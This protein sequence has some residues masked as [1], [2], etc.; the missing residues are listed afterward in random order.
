MAVFWQFI[1]LSILISLFDITN[2]SKNWVKENIGQ[3][4][5]WFYNKKS[6]KAYV[7]TEQGVIA[8][9]DIE[10]EGN[11][12]WRQVLDKDDKINQFEL[13][14][15]KKSLISLSNSDVLRKW[16][17]LDGSLVWESK[18]FTKSNNNNNN[19]N[20]NNAD[21][22]IIGSKIV[23]IDNND[24]LS[25]YDEEEGTLIWK[26][27]IIAN[28]DKNS[29][30]TRQYKL[31]TDQIAKTVYITIFYDDSVI[32]KSYSLTTVKIN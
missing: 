16:K 30:K 18:Q 2:S 29:N 4:T 6:N 22:Q 25:V 3:V 13:S 7:S 17:K 10:N 1:L 28:D 26:Q 20:N 5:N 19:N 8:S 23:L 32:V 9:I 24:F 11:I 21:M 12:L 14:S 27:L 15:D 31:Y